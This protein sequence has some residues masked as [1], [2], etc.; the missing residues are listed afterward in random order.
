MGV[1]L[2]APHRSAPMTVH[3]LT[4]A[5]APGRASSSN[6]WPAPRAWRRAAGCTSATCCRA[7]TPSA[8]G[9]ARRSSPMNRVD[10]G[11]ME[12]VAL[13]AL[14]RGR[15]DGT[16]AARGGGRR[17]ARRGA[18]GG[19]GWSPPTTTCRRSSSTA[20][21]ACASPPCTT[22]RSMPPAATS[23][24]RFRFTASAACRSTTRSSS[25]SCS[26][27]ERN[28]SHRGSV[29][30]RR[31]GDREG[32]VRAGRAGARGACPSRCASRR[33]ARRSSRPTWD[34]SGSS[35]APDGSTPSSS[36]SP[37]SR[38]PR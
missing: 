21:A 9:G 28:G 15:G 10:A 8:T 18:A 26:E 24:P 13:Y 11:D 1:P 27:G 5:D 7:S 20:T 37:T 3:E 30:G 6:A 16:R 33:T 23:S 36:R 38:P 29:H 12:V 35:L 19:C 32:G 2:L 31:I 22:A 34:S 17:R 4:A 25:R 14:Q